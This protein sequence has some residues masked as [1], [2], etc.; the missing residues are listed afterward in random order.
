MASP[1]PSDLK[2]LSP[3]SE[4]PT[5]SSY[6]SPAEES[7]DLSLV[8]ALLSL[9]LV[10][11]PVDS[12]II[13]D[14]A[15]TNP[16]ESIKR[17]EGLEEIQIKQQTISLNTSSPPF[18]PVP[19]PPSTSPQYIST[20]M[21]ILPPKQGRTKAKTAVILQEACLKHVYSRNNDIGTI[22]ER[23]QRIRAVKMGVAGCL[24]RMEGR[25]R[26]KASRQRNETDQKGE[27]E[28]DS[29]RLDILMSGM[30]IGEKVDVKGKGREILGGP[31]DII[32]STRLLSIDD[33]ALL[34]I[35]GRPHDSSGYTHYALPTTSPTKSPSKASTSTAVQ[36]PA[37]CIPY[38]AELQNWC[39]ASSVTMRSAPNYSE[40]P[41]HLNQGDLYLIEGSEQAILG[42]V[43]A[44]CDGIDLV[45]R[46]DGQ[47]HSEDVPMESAY[48]KVFVAIRPPGHVS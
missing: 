21:E 31:F 39:R 37:V 27:D 9:R 16:A 19:K 36:L 12:T 5:P 10:G 23:P 38:A 40:V 30:D 32:E 1:S 34:Y 20:S 14:D 24:A 4:S 22:V 8:D 41:M 29:K 33:P 13:L 18:D 15:G 48:E 42:S 35:H 44:V 26:R 7:E 45:L 46:Q 47:V 17:E 25:E 11:A 2:P 28:E 6:H 43:G 3:A